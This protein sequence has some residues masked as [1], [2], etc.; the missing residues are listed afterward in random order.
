M[1]CTT[2]SAN[3]SRTSSARMRRATTNAKHSRVY[4]STTYSGTEDAPHRHATV[5]GEADCKMRHHVHGVAQGGATQLSYAVGARGKSQG[6][7][8]TATRKCRPPPV[9][10]RLPDRLAKAAEPQVAPV[11]LEDVSPIEFLKD[12][13]KGIGVLRATDAVA[14]AVVI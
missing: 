12:K 14:G 5:A 6:R 2:N 8:G 11:N 1:T 9:Q 3:T 7:Q 13:T 4:S 10:N